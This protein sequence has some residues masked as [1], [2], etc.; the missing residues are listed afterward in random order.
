MRGA[1]WAVPGTSASLR[2]RGPMATTPEKARVDSPT[3]WG[4]PSGPASPCV[5]AHTRP[6]HQRAEAGSDGRP[7]HW[8]PEVP[9]CLK[10]RG[11]GHPGRLL[12]VPRV[13]LECGGLPSGGPKSAGGAAGVF[14]TPRPPS[15][16][17][18]LPPVI[19]APSSHHIYPPHPPPASEKCGS[20]EQWKPVGVTGIRAW[21]PCQHGPATSAQWVEEKAVPQPSQSPL[22]ESMQAHSAHPPPPALDGNAT[23]MPTPLG[24]N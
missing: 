9:Y 6:L 10:P 16:N 20:L 21:H 11:R 1:G 8:W 22:P 5:R 17:N 3:C 4:C 15:A 2:P 13:G 12:G 18:K 14:L 24:A 19:C 7:G 23:T